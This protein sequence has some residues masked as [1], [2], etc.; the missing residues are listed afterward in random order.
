LPSDL[1]FGAFLVYPPRPDSRHGHEIRNFVL[2]L[3]EDR[4]VGG[5]SSS[6]HV[7]RRLAE[8]SDAAELRSFL[9]DAVLVPAPKSAPLTTGAL[10]A[11]LRIAQAL[12]EHSVGRAVAAVIERVRPIPTSHLV[13]GSARAWPDQHLATLALRR[14]LPIDFDGRLVIVDDV[15]TRGSTLLGCALA[16]RES[17]PTANVVGF[18]A[19]RTLKQEETMPSDAVQPILGT[20]EWTEG[21]INRSP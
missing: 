15:V 12:H 3:K 10:W 19:A 9:A 1:D 18:A 21:W 14:E 2:G 16:L 20:I 8:R 11:S 7:A 6:Q 13:G 5:V 17:Y 4:V